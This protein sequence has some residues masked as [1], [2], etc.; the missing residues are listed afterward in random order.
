MTKG[1]LEADIRAAINKDLPRQV[2]DALKERLASIPDLEKAKDALAAK[3]EQA[4]AERSALLA[5][6]DALAKRLL[7]AGKLD[8][9]EAAVEAREC[10]AARQQ[11]EHALKC[12][13]RVTATLTEVLMGLVR[14][15]TFK[16]TVFGSENRSHVVP[17]GSGG[18]YT[19]NTSDNSNSTVE[20]RAE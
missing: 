8:E 20:R 7:Q 6:R 19:T 2:G 18:H 1:D 12:E 4:G 13:A 5:E 9:R 3:L 11:L 17:T 10:E 15:T 14:N 16:E